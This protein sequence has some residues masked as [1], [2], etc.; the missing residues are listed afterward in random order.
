MDGL[1]KVGKFIAKVKRFQR[2]VKKLVVNFIKGLFKV[3]RDNVSRRLTDFR[4]VNDV[5][6][7]IKIVKNT[8][9]GN[10]A[11]LVLMYDIFETSA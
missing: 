4:E 5:P 2:A 10:L 11:S 7:Y 9:A 3:A 6:K 8:P 1:D